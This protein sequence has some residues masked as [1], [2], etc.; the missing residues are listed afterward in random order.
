M[1]TNTF[2]DFPS[3]G[4]NISTPDFSTLI[5][6]QVNAE[7]KRAT[8]TYG[9]MNTEHEAYAIILEEI[10]E[11]W[12][13]IKLKPNQRSKERMRKEAIQ[14]MAMLARFIIDCEL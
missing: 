10:D 8:S 6:L 5:F 2:D 3:I 7:L 9:P 13:E 12:A 14:C 11:L 4:N 1:G